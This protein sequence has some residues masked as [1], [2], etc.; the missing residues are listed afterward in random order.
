MLGGHGNP[1]SAHRLGAQARRALEEAR[2]TVARLLGAEP[3]EVIFTSGATESN[4]LAVLGLCGDPPGHL[5]AS[6]VEHPCVVEPLR[7]LQRR[8]FALDWLPVDGAGH[9][10]AD[11]LAPLLRPDTRLVAVML[12]NHETG[13]LQPV[14]RL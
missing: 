12:A 6:P 7:Q 3:R 14:V 13:T 11:A 2:D 1:A 10:P 4:N 9:V 5:I 8:G